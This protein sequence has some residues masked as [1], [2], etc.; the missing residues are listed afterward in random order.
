MKIELIE[1]RSP[2]LLITEGNIM[3]CRKLIYLL[4]PLYKLSHHSGRKKE[5]LI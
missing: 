3:R 1:T 4:L 5:E 2:L